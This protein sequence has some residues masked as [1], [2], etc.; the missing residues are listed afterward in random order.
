MANS[1]SAKPDVVTY[2]DHEMITPDTSKLRRMLRP[3]LPGEP[4]PLVAAEAALAAIS[5]DFSGWMKDECQRLDDARRK[6]KQLGLYTE[7]RQELFLAAH[8]LKGA[9][10]TLGYPEVSPA[11]DSLCRLLEHSPDLNKIPMAIIDQ[12]VDAIRAIVREHSRADIAAI[13]TALTGKLR[14]VTDEF[15]LK[16]NRDRPEVL[17]TIRSPSIAS[18]DGF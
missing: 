3:A 9:A 13:G 1:K 4:D 10:V 8:D 11:A 14:T 2:G 18:G 12:H 16:E 7:T 17:K 5:G 15:L 6:V